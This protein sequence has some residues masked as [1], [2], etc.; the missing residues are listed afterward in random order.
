[1][2]P[3]LMGA[4]MMSCRFRNMQALMRLLAHHLQREKGSTAVLGLFVFVTMLFVA[5]LAI[6]MMR[7][8]T[9]RVRMQGASDRAV[10]AAASVR[11]NAPQSLSA[12]QIAEAYLTAGGLSAELIEGRVE[13][14]ESETGRQVTVAPAGSMPTIFM[15]MMG[16]NSFDMAT[17]ARALEAMGDPPDIEVVMVLDVSGSMNWMTSNGL[18]RI[19]NLRVAARD[20]VEE[21]FNDT[22]PG[23]VAVTLVPYDSWVLPPAGFMNSFANF[24][25]GSG[26]C[27]DF[28]E[29]NTATNSINAQFTRHSCNTANWRLVRP[30][31]DNVDDAIEH[32]ENLVASSTT[33]IDLGVRFGAMFFDPTIRP[34]IQ[35]MVDNGQISQQFAGRPHEWDR[36]NV[37]R[38]MVLMTDGENCCFGHN[39]RSPNRQTQDAQTVAACQA[40][41]QQDV[42]IYA[43]AFEAPPGGVDMMQQCASSENHFFNTTGDGIAEVFRSIGSHIQTQR[44]RLTL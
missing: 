21:L 34:A 20:L 18:S 39:S 35:Q 17:P 38:A 25:A 30:Y 14:I 43:V 22:E 37:I 24:P 16:V 12:R 9:E 26:A 42:L 31:L 7:Y 33:S 15:R 27:A 1:M 8:E 10:L 41:R 2:P 44:L 13:V 36:E 23:Q 3:A 4:G 40:L 6:D 28:T 19:A 32:I 29:W 11:P 5:G